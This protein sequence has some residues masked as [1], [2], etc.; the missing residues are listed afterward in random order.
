MRKKILIVDDNADL[1]ELLRLSF[2]EAGYSIA[3]ATNG[4]EALKKAAS[5][6]PDLVLL[7]LVLPEMDGFA[8][9]ETLRRSP[10]TANTPILLMS[11]LTSQLSRLAG[12]ES[13]GT[14]FV[15]KP[16]SPSEL[17]SKTKRL[18]RPRR[19]AL[20]SPAT[21]PSSEGPALPRIS[22]K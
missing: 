5:L 12:L 8:V 2:K 13:G 22:S 17:V 10:A 9:C 15:T 6:A 3:T 7:D 1:L 16:V 20:V 21:A 11:G 19:A 4:I 18:L 14:D